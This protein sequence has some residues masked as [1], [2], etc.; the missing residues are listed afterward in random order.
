MT[1]R[2]GKMGSP[3]AVLAIAL[4]TRARLMADIAR[5]LLGHT[6]T[7]TFAREAEAALR[8][9]C[10]YRHIQLHEWRAGEER[11]VIDAPAPAPLAVREW[12]LVV[13]DG[14]VGH[15]IVDDPPERTSHAAL[16]ALLPWLALG[17][18]QVD[19]AVRL[20]ESLAA[21]ESH[22]ATLRSIQDEFD[23]QASTVVEGPEGGDKRRA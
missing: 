16:E 8:D 15:L 14:Q 1:A 23:A 19:A 9:H 3:G 20:H 21:I 5:S 7:A 22:V 13:G 17:L 12:R 11:V 4:G 18:Q 2:S 10:G 6:T